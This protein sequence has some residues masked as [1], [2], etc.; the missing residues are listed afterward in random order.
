MDHDDIGIAIN[1][2]KIETD[3]VEDFGYGYCKCRS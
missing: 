1:Q 2:R 3:V